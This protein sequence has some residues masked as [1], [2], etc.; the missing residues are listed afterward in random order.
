MLDFEFASPDD[1][2]RAVAKRAREMRLA[3]DL[4]QEGLAARSGVSLGSLKRFESTGAISLESLARLAIT[5]RA[6]DGFGGL[7][8]PRPFATM[9][10]V[11]AVPPAKRRRGR[12]S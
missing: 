11:L 7:F 10:E 5:L 9:A 6:E 8:S 1:L 2:C 12:K 3:A 4:T